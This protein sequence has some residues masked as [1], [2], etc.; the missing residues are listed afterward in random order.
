MCRSGAGVDSTQ[1]CKTIVVATAEERAPEAPSELRDST[2]RVRYWN[3]ALPEW[4]VGHS[5]K[6]Q[7]DPAAMVTSNWPETAFG[8]MTIRAEQTADNLRTARLRLPDRDFLGAYWC[9]GDFATAI[10]F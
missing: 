10:G 9:E 1:P 2:R 6:A 7:I 4:I 8:E 3:V 5:Y